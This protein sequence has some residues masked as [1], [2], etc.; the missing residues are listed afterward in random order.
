MATA[1]R[2]SI[3]AIEIPNHHAIGKRRELRQRAMRR[4][5]Y[6]RAARIAHSQRVAPGNRRGLGIK[7][8]ERTAQSIDE[9]PFAVVH[10]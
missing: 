4:T 1:A 7:R 10:D 3:V 2:I 6:R 8:G 9:P 5:H